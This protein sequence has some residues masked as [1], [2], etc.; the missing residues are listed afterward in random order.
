MDFVEAQKIN[1]LRKTKLFRKSTKKNIDFYPCTETG[2]SHATPSNKSTPGSM[3]TYESSDSQ[4]ATTTVITS[5]LT[6]T[7]EAA[8]NIFSVN[9]F[10]WPFMAM[11][12]FSLQELN[13]SI[14]CMHPCVG[15]EFYDIG[16]KARRGE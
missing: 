2:S 13:T 4:E 5:S 12:Y 15:I 10:I 6:P 7:A 9:L 8:G 14:C 16:S 1:D 11:D 3:S